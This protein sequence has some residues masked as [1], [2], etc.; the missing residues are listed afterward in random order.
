MACR[1]YFVQQHANGIYYPL[2]VVGMALLSFSYVPTFAVVLNLK[3]LSW[4][5]AVNPVLGL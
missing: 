3:Q 4:R 2:A 1:C 5:A